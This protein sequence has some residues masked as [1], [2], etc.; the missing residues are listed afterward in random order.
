MK[1]AVE[2]VRKLIPDANITV[3]PGLTNTIGRAVKYDATRVKEEIGFEPKWK[4]E[5]GIK[6]TIEEVRQQ[7]KGTSN[8]F[9]F[10]R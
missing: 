3:L 10:E 4:M 9:N 6:K 7:F 5:E 1:E 8:N 2:Y